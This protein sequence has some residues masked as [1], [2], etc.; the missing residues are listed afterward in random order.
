MLAV[1]FAPRFAEGYA[2]SLPYELSFT[3]PMTIPDPSLY[4]NDCCWGGDVVRD[5]LLP[6]VFGTYQ[7]IQTEQEDW[8][9]FIWFSDR[10]TRLAIDI[11][12]DDIPACKFRIH[13]TS[14]RKRF[15]L[16]SVVADTPELERLREIVTHEIA[17][18]IGASAAIEHID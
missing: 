10:E 15:L 9:W 3:A 5:R 8:G 6:M 11:H 2:V 16:P 4:I 18:W 17:R 1:E 12:C 14:R 7:R 13:L